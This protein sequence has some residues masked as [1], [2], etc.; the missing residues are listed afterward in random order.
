MQNNPSFYQTPTTEKGS[1]PLNYQN[2][3]P[4]FNPHQNQ[5]QNGYN[6]IR[7]PPLPH[8]NQNQNHGQQQNTYQHQNMYAHHST[9]RQGQYQN[10]FQNQNQNQ[11]QFQQ[12]RQSNVEMSQSNL[13]QSN[14]SQN[15][16][17]NRPPIPQM[18]YQQGNGQ[19]IY[20]QINGNPSQNQYSNQQNQSIG[21]NSNQQRQGYQTPF[22]QSNRGG[23]NESQDI[24]E[25]I[26]VN[27]RLYMNN[28]SSCCS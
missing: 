6:N 10:Q 12:R 3:S 15:Q 4:R 23:G 25:T 7:L 16:M 18:Q 26:R 13:Q 5:N 17:C 2:E 9:Q 27:Y 24:Q 22:I 8:Q 1:L 19:Q 28:L 14:H 20:N 11:N 21:S